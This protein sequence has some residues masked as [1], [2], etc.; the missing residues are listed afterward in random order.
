MKFTALGSA[1]TGNIAVFKMDKTNVI[2][3][4]PVNSGQSVAIGEAESKGVEFEC[5]ANCPRNSGSRLSYAYT[6]AEWGTSVL[7]PDFRKSS[8]RAIRRSTSRNTTPTSSCSR[9]STSAAGT[10]TF[11]AGAKYISKR[12]GETGTDFCLPTTRRQIARFLRSD[13]KL[14][15]SW[16]KSPICLDEEY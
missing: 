5:R 4:D 1:L 13:R 2:T 16:K 9:I 12:L 11:G 3:A 15:D 10:L 14:H 8:R 7:D 6:E